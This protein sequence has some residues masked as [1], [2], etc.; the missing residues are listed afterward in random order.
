MQANVRRFGRVD[1]RQQPYD[2]L[3]A[4]GKW[5]PEAELRDFLGVQMG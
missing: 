4:N 2:V 5:D 3:L 1:V